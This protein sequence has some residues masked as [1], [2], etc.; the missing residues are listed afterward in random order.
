LV[1]KKEGIT[2]KSVYLAY[3]S[4]RYIILQGEHFV[5]EMKTASGKDKI[6]KR[7]QTNLT[8]YAE[9]NESPIFG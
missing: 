6:L 5:H 8:V 3:H 7:N 2:A 4:S 9:W 1:W